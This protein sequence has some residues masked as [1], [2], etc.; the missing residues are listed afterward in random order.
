MNS[1]MTASTLIRRTRSLQRAVLLSALA[2]GSMSAQAD[3][4]QEMAKHLAERLPALEGAEVRPSPVEGIY[5]V[6]HRR[7][8]AYATH[9]AR[10][11]FAG[12]LL[13]VENKRNLTEDVERERRANELASASEKSMIIFE[14]EGPVQI[15]RAHV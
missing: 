10:F 6:H 15:G 5:E 11:V 2:L 8:I 7:G 3:H 12:P 1:M 13:D 4:F 9:D 14:P